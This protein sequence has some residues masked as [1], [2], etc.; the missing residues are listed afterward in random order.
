MAEQL[1]C[2]VTGATG[3]IG[4]RLV[5]RL[6]DHGFA[7]RALARTPEKLAGV[8]WRES[9]EV[10]RG[11]LSD[12]AAVEEVDVVYYLVHSMGLEKD[13]AAEERCAAQNL[14]AAARRGRRCGWRPD[15]RLRRR[16]G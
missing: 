6:L 15:Q 13:F 10:T 8:P 1:R 5:P 11:D 12:E 4:G 9:I 2:L 14:V 7:V 3:Y 16:R